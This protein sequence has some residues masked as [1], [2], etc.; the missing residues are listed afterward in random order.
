MNN[1]DMPDYWM[2]GKEK[3][4]RADSGG[5]GVVIYSYRNGWKLKVTAE[6]PTVRNHNPANLYYG[7][8]G[9]ALKKAKAVG[10]LYVDK[11]G[12]AVFPDWLTGK[13]AAD[14]WW[15]DARRSNLTID[16]AMTTFL[17]GDE[18]GAEKRK[19]DLEAKARGYRD[20]HGSPV[21]KSTHLSDLTEEQFIALRNYSNLQ[22]EGW[23]NNLQ[24]A[25]IEWIPPSPSAHAPAGKA[26]VPTSPSRPHSSLE[27]PQSPTPAASLYTGSPGRLSQWHREIRCY[28][29]RPLRDSQPCPPIP[30][31]SI[32]PQVSLLPWRTPLLPGWTP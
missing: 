10:A 13:R 28:P 19:K 29:P 15:E 26:L 21:N 24:R 31:L 9:A 14:K 8:G 7:H 25:K 17:S 12:F 16:E 4:E 32:Q 27:V 20:R 11:D 18:P 6:K 2:E 22:L 5:E 1:D 23:F 30:L 3:P